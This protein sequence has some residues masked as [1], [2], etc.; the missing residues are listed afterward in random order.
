MEQESPGIRRGRRG[1]AFYM[2]AAAVIL[3]CLQGILYLLMLDST[4]GRI[5]ILKKENAPEAA[6]V[7]EVKVVILKSSATA[8]LF[9]E[10]PTTYYMRERYWEAILSGAGISYNVVSERDLAPA[11]ARA[12]VLVLPGVNCIGSEQRKNIEDFLRA[13]RGVVAS[14]SLGVRDQNCGWQGWDFLVRLIG[15]T[16]ASASTP[17]ETSFVALRNH[18]P[19]SARVPGGYMLT[20]PS[21]ELTSATVPDPDAVQT[22]WRLRALASAGAVQPALAAH[23]EVDGGRVVWFGFSETF[24]T[25]RA[26][27][28][29]MFDRFALGAL[30]WAA[31]QPLTYVA[32]WP[33]HKQ[34]AAIVA[35][36]VHNRYDDAQRTAFLLKRKSVPATFFVSSIE[37]LQHPSA[38][39]AFKDAGEIAAAGDRYDSFS[40]GSTIEQSDRLQRAKQALTG[41]AGQPVVGFAPPFGA[42]DNATI[43]ALNDAG[44]RYYLNETAVSRAVPELVDF[45][46]QSPAFP[47]QKR[48]VTKIFRV[49][50]DDVELLANERASS[51]PD[52]A[53]GFMA[54][55]RR[56]TYFGGVYPL[57]FHDFLLGAPEYRPTLERL[58]D[59]MK[60]EPV[61][62]ASGRDIVRWWSARQRVQATVKRLSLHRI[63]LDLANMGDDTVQNACVYVY[64]PYRPKTVG[65]RSTLF[66]LQ[67]PRFELMDKDDLMRVDVGDLKG[68]TNYNYIISLD[69]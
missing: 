31:R 48:Q 65:I 36:S 39:Q 66:R 25:E 63:Q 30:S 46:S 37:A 56:V 53:G 67:P 38:V 52:L 51:G 18:R 5:S 8:L 45:P 41:M 43:L 42:S 1:F 16:G 13:G 60:A 57:Y 68:Q 17:V 62:I 55:L 40:G 34:A 12:T 47:L 69:E 23:H 24:P 58:L 6:L 26:E 50:S 22:D 64:L 2:L 4:V 32:D 33:D 54:E 11:L 9:P 28:Q 44:Y 49:A 10:S 27:V 7:R 14:G 59:T 20:V 15:A 19:F 35:E 3:L 21:Q 29:Q 61:W